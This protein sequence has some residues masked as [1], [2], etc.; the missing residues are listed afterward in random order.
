MRHSERSAF[1][2][3]MKRPL[4]TGL[5]GYDIT[6]KI[7]PLGIQFFD[8]SQLPTSVPFFYLFLSHYGIDHVFMGFIPNKAIVLSQK[9]LY[10]RHPRES[11]GPVFKLSVGK[12]GNIEKG[13][14]PGFPPSRE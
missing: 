4:L 9:S 1:F 2:R 3:I 11:G 7:M 13:L 5:Q 12:D 6:I 14:Q 10:I 8:E